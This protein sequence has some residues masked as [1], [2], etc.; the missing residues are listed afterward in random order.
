MYLAT[1]SN[2]EISNKAP[3]RPYSWQ[4]RLSGVQTGLGEGR[5]ESIVG[6]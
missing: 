1:Y 5:V 6:S 4:K 2:L 3:H